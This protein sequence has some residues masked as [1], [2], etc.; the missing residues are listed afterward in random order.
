MLPMLIR[1]GLEV[2]YILEL[3][4]ASHDQ[5][6][7]LAKHNCIRWSTMFLDSDETLFNRGDRMS[8]VWANCGLRSYLNGEFLNDFTL[9]EINAIAL[10]KRNAHVLNV[11]TTAGTVSSRTK[12]MFANYVH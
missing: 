11:G 1:L 6:R 5:F 3:L 8:N 7:I 9:A 10:S 4:T 2:M 12:E